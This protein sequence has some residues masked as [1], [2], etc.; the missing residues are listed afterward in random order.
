MN[1][2]PERPR[3]P[4]HQARWNEPIIYELGSP[5]ERGVLPPGIDPAIGAGAQNWE[6]HIPASMRRKTPPNLPEISQV[7]I[8]R[9]YLR[10]SQETLGAGLIPDFGMATSTMKYNPPV[11][12]KLASNPKLA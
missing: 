10:L 11:N 3:R 5:G 2:I 6:A 9:H 4:Y 7:E 8:L 1:H 12:E